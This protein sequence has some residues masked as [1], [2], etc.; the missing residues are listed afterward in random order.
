MAGTLYVV[1][2]SGERLVFDP[3]GLHFSA[4]TAPSEG[5]SAIVVK[6]KANPTPKPQPKP[7]KSKG[8]LPPKPI[9]IDMSLMAGLPE[10]LNAK[11]LWLSTG[12]PQPDIPSIKGVVTLDLLRSWARDIPDGEHRVLILESDDGE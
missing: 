2:K 11:A 1:N 5:Y 9:D 7:I 12:S 8:T 6:P 3:D 4:V 10:D